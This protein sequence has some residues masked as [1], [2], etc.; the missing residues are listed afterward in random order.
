MKN[1]LF[2]LLLA[3]FPV[4]AAESTASLE[5]LRQAAVQGNVDAEYEIGI[6]Y[7][8]GYNFPDHKAAAYAWYNRA[9]ERGNALAAKRRDVLKS[10]LSAAEIE[11]SQALLKSPAPSPAPASPASAATR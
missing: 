8:F 9:A 2:A 5:T 11:R 6:L 10:Q 1:L 3:T 4:L 7:E